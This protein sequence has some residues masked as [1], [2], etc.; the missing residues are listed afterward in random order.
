MKRME[1]GGKGRGEKK[2]MR[3]WAGRDGILL[4]G[5]GCL[6]CGCKDLGWTPDMNA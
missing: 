5:K 2:D 4:R 3:R 6:L 1:I